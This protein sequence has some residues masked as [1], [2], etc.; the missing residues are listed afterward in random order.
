[1]K[2][3]WIGDV[4][5][6]VSDLA[7]CE[8]LIRHVIKTA[9][10]TK[11]DHIVFA[12]DQYHTHA[13]INSYVMEF[14]KKTFDS[15]SAYEVWAL[16]GNHDMPGVE[17]AT[18]NS[19]ILHDNVLV[20]DRPMFESGVLFLPYYANAASFVEECNKH[21]EFPTVMCH[22]EFN[23]CFYENGF[24]S[25]FGV[26]PNLIIQKHVISGHIHAPQE[27]GK[28]LY[29]GAPRWQTLSDANVD[30]AIWLFEFDETGTVINKK[31]YSTAG[32]CKVIRHFEHTPAI[33]L[34]PDLTSLMLNSTVHIDLRGPGDFVDAQKELLTP[35]GVRLRVFKT[36]TRPTLVRESMGVQ[37]AFQTYLEGFVPP[38]KTERDVLEKM[39]AERIN[40]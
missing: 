16:V 27:F 35:L 2:I 17:G 14:W 3:L 9:D 6:K 37:K 36:D 21:Q 29:P 28:V 26:D 40:G 18:A 31:G 5:A 7:D 12:G 10:L 8:A 25:K 38:N 39:Y 32:V 19:M 22:Q 34:P 13:I 20:V 11:P 30:R 33:P 23:G 4:H 15:L 24:Y 1:M